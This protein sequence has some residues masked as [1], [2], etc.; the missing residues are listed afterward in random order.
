[1]RISFIIIF[2]FIFGSIQAQQPSEVSSQNRVFVASGLG[3]GFPVGDISQTLSPKVSNVLGLNIPLKSTRYFLYPVVDFLRFSYDES[4]AD[5]EFEFQLSN[6]NSN[7]Y[8]L[9]VMPG[10]NQFLGSLRL[11][12]YAGPSL[13]LIYEPRIEV[14]QLEQRATIEKTASLTGGLRGGLGAHYQIGDFYL[15]VE[16]AYLRNFNKMQG[17]HL[18]VITLHGGL[19]TDVTKL[20]EKI[21]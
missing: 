1:M 20:V 16:S 9:S 13:Q 18:G 19:K 2:V 5:P 6:G 8:G 17:N 11:Y 10:V 4:V 7:L 14:D 12:A 15:F 21:F 3:F